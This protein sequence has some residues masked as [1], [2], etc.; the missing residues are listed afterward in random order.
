MVSTVGAGDV[1]CCLV[2]LARDDGAVPDPTTW[3]WGPDLSGTV[4]GGGGAAAVGGAAKQ[5]AAA[6]ALSDS[7]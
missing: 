6:R 3:P 4:G 7:L 5:P 1:W 2:A